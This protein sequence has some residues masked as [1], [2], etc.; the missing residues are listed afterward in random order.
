MLWHSNFLRSFP[1]G[2]SH[3]PILQSTWSFRTCFVFWRYFRYRAGMPKKR[4]KLCR[5]IYW[6][7]IQ[8]FCSLHFSN[9][10]NLGRLEMENGCWS[11]R[12]RPNLDIRAYPVCLLVCFILLKTNRAVHQYF[13]GTEE[14]IE[15]KILSPGK[16]FTGPEMGQNFYL[17]RYKMNLL[18]W[19]LSIKC[20]F[21]HRIK[22]FYYSIQILN[23]IYVIL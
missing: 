2:P 7:F 1:V 10:H 22:F 8:R 21:R 5:I 15:L 17:M 9:R 6:F 12:K 18:A 3:S 20:T 4:V 11:T 14:S 13:I 23:I 19:C 16:Q